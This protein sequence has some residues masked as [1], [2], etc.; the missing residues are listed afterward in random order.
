MTEDAKEVSIA[1]PRSSANSDELGDKESTIDFL[2]D[3]ILSMMIFSDIP[4]HPYRDGKNMF[5]NFKHKFPFNKPT[6]FDSSQAPVAALVDEMVQFIMTS[7]AHIFN[8]VKDNMNIPLTQDAM[9]L[10]HTL[11]MTE[12]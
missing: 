3:D 12:P 11:Q 4:A 6:G 2:T 5:Q 9:S 10:L 7:P 8:K 1:S